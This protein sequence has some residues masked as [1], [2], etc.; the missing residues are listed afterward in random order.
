MSA[1]RLLARARRDERGSGDVA[2]LVVAVPLGLATVLLF[3][4]LGRQGAAAEGVTHAAAVAARAAAMERSSA[5]ATSAAAAMA[6]TTLAASGESCAGGPDVAIT[7]SRWE[8]GGV[9]TVTVTCRIAG[10]AS[11]GARVRTVSGT[12][13]A[14]IDRYW[15]YEP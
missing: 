11:I 8:P 10:V 6:A 2:A 14:T 5:A 4:M 9:V 1:R 13:R 7:A 12:A 15:A 3:V